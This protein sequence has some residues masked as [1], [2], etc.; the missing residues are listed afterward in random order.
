MY[1]QD[2]Y[3]KIQAITSNEVENEYASFNGWSQSTNVG[4]VNAVK[5]DLDRVASFDPRP[6]GVARAEPEKKFYDSKTKAWVSVNASQF[7]ETIKKKP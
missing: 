6:H 7:P 5:A 2:H 1:H 3:P 4:W